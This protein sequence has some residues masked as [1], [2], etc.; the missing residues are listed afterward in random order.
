MEADIDPRTGLTGLAHLLVQA[1]LLDKKQALRYQEIAAQ[2]KLRLQQYLVRSNIIPSKIIAMSLAQSLDLPFFDLDDI[3]ANAIPIAIVSEELML[4]HHMLPLW[5]QENFLCIA[6]DDPSHQQALKELQFHTGFVIRPYIVETH[7][8]DTHL[9][10]LVYQK[11]H[12]TIVSYFSDPQH[13]DSSFDKNEI[14]TNNEDAPVVKYV[15]KI[16][17]EAIKKGVSD[18]HFETY[19]DKYRIRYRLDGILHEMTS[20][21]ISLAT[22]IAARIKLMAQMDITERRTPQDG[23]FKLALPHAHHINF[24]VS[25]CP[26]VAGEK[27]VVRLLDTESTKRD[28]QDLGFNPLQKKIFLKN[29]HRAQGMILVTGPTGS[30]KTVTLYSALNLLNT[31]EKNISTAEDPVE[32]NLSG[33]NQ[34]QINSKIGLS[35]SDTLR[36]FLRQDPDVIMIGEIRDLETAE[37]A[38]KAAQ[39]G[40]LVLSTLHTNSAAETLIRL[41]NIGVAAFNIVSSISLVIAQRLAR[42]LCEHCKHIRADLTLEH[43]G[44]LGFSEAEAKTA[45]IYQAHGCKQCMN[46]YAGRIALFE[47]MHMSD[48]LSQVILSKGSPQAIVQQAQKEGMTTLYQDGIE[49]VKAGITSLE[50][51]TRV[52][53]GQCQHG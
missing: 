22:R 45:Q 11:E 12:Q 30:G 43:R 15:N 10:Q 17:L 52:T 36:A 27:I 34:V 49:K 44:M 25:T 26:T 40:H 8:L 53:I 47:V 2:K 51:I 16:F 50:E 33:I 46:G 39:T 7:K 18:L 35:F 13:S 38:M 19:I 42:R 48:K 1:N 20:P 31:G 41:A 32:L 21:P 6:M 24:R 3:D 29:I 28:I 9:S 4:R 23:R 5:L 14:E 37:I